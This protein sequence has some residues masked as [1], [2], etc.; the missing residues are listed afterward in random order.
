MSDTFSRVKKTI[1][2]VIGSAEDEVNTDATL[3]GLGINSLDILELGMALEE[4][5]DVMIMDEYLLSS[6]TVGD[7]VETVN[8]ARAQQTCSS[9]ATV[10]QEC[11]P[12]RA[13]SSLCWPFQISRLRMFHL[14]AKRSK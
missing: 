11:A 12:T 4:E 13:R 14:L 9:A 2:A 7:L 5:F 6:K 8:N 10:E 3:N 1:V